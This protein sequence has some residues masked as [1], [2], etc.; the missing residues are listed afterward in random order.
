[1]SEFVQLDEEQIA[2]YQ[3]FHKKLRVDMEKAL[4]KLQQLEH[5]QEDYQLVIEYIKNNSGQSQMKM[6]VGANTFLDVELV[7]P[8]MITLDVGMNVFVELNFSEA[9]KI[10]AKQ[11]QILQNKIEEQKKS[12][13]SIQQ[14]IDQVEE[15]LL[16][17]K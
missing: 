12:I 10:T 9:E 13:L 7:N 3:T 8:L 4:Q 16:Q 11:I 17:F 6:N 15:I 5:K 14:Y 2:K 1:M